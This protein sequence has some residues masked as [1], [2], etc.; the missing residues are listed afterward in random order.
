MKKSGSK[1]D[2]GLKYSD[3]GSSDEEE[4]HDHEDEEKI[5]DFKTMLS[6]YREYTEITSPF[7][8]KIIEDVMFINEK[9][10][11]ALEYIF[12]QKKGANIRRMKKEKNRTE[13]NSLGID[14]Y[15]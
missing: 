11:V 4:E 9:K 10:V 14:D 13:S 6:N 8:K 15:P 3:T 2:K 1:W 7:N 12:Y 5:I